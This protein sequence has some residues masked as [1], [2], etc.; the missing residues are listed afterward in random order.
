[1]TWPLTALGLSYMMISEAR[2]SFKRM[3]PVLIDEHLDDT[4]ETSFE[5]NDSFAQIQNVNF[6]YPKG[7][8][9]FKD[10]SLNL[11][12]ESSYLITG[13]TKSGKTTLFNILNGLTRVK[14]GD[15]KVSESLISNPQ[16]PFLFMDTVDQ[17]ISPNGEIV[18]LNRLKEVAFDREYAD[19]TYQGTTLIGEKGTSL[20]GGQ[21]QR[22]S[23]LRALQTNSK[24]L[25]LDEPVSAVDEKTKQK[26]IESLKTSG[27]Q[28][29]IATSNPE[30]YTWMDRVLLIEESSNKPRSERTV[31][32]LSMAEAHQ[33]QNFKDLLRTKKNDL[34]AGDLDEQK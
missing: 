28:L 26:I 13:K 10:L 33:N 12:K 17:N 27:K 18:T 9:F 4:G 3:K 31:Q 34:N 15:R 6:S 19:L 21:K 20:S 24:I 23:L 5:K 11:K 29:V 25:F 7:E 14:S 16:I 22:L 8:T 1:M 32:N 2:S 30:H